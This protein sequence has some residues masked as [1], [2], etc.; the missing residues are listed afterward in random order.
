MPT[1]RLASLIAALVPLLAR[2]VTPVWALDPP[3][4]EL[5]RQGGDRA[6]EYWH[7]RPLVRNGQHVTARRTL[8]GHVTRISNHV[9]LT[10]YENGHVVNPLVPGRLTPYHDSTAPTVRSIALRR[11]DAGRE[12]LPTFVRG[13]VETLPFALV[14]VV[15]LSAATPW[16]SRLVA[17]LWV[18][19]A[20]NWM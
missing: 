19:F 9:H 5:W 8:L 12:L 14:K 1:I 2:F 10:E 6:F 17:S 3:F 16:I 7:I 15:A 20:S 4:H 13:R 18:S 11:T